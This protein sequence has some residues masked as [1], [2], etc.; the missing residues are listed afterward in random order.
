MYRDDAK[1][2]AETIKRMLT[3]PTRLTLLFLALL[4]LSFADVYL[5]PHPFE[6]IF[7][8]SKP[9]AAV[10]GAIVWTGIGLSGAWTA[11]KVL[12]TKAKKEDEKPEIIQLRYAVVLFILAAGVYSAL[13]VAFGDLPAGAGYTVGGALPRIHVIPHLS[14]DSKRRGQ[15]KGP[16]SAADEKSTREHPCGDGRVHMHLHCRHLYPTSY[17][18]TGCFLHPT[19]TLGD[20]HGIGMCNHP[21]NRSDV[22]TMDSKRNTNLKELPRSIA[23]E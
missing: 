17:H 8:S 15:A 13:L 21:R 14:M 5:N 12:E 19:T 6:S 20:P 11:M 22:G 4:G 16:V 23:D 7:S 10:I 2:G 3:S 18:A 9:I 1:R